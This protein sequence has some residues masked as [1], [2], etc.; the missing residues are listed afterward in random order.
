MNLS[1]VVY[2]YNGTSVSYKTGNPVIIRWMCV[3]GIIL[4]EMSDRKK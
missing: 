2:I 4:S 3:E 1:K